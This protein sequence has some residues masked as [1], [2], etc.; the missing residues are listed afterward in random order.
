MFQQLQMRLEQN[1]NN[2][3]K[4]IFAV[5]RRTKIINCYDQTQWILLTMPSNNLN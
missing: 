2:E 1:T 4:N 3:K 5:Y